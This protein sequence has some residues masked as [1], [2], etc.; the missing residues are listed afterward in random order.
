MT[1]TVV[2]PDP[3]VGLW[4]MGQ[5]EVSGLDTCSLRSVELGVDSNWLGPVPG[6]LLGCSA[7]LPSG[8]G[9]PVVR[10]SDYPSHLGLLLS[11]LHLSPW[12]S[13]RNFPAEMYPVH[14]GDAGEEQGRYSTFEREAFR[15]GERRPHKLR[16]RHRPS[17][18]WQSGIKFRDTSWQSHRYLPLGT[19]NRVGQDYEAQL[20]SVTSFVET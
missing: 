9:A 14:Y 16:C 10:T 6:A 18:P 3:P 20:F 17:M 15:A 19:Q 12:A 11:L 4:S 13:Q 8:S 1:P 7:A 5:W 2:P